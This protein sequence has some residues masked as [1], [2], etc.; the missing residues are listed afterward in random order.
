MEAPVRSR[1]KPDAEMP[2]ALA[3]KVSF[4]LAEIRRSFSDMP[5][6]GA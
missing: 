5:T 4:G 1:A 3:S 6:F 2:G